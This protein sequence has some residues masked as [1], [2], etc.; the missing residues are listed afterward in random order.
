M[1]LFARKIIATSHRC[2]GHRIRSTRNRW[3]A[4]WHYRDSR[5]RLCVTARKRCNSKATCSRGLQFGLLCQLVA[6]LSRRMSRRSASRAETLSIAA[7]RA[8]PNRIRSSASQAVER[9]WDAQSPHLQAF[10]RAKQCSAITKPAHYDVVA[11]RG[12]VAKVAQL[13][14]EWSQT[15]R[16]SRSLSSRAARTPKPDAQN[17]FAH[18]D[19]PERAI[20][21]VT[22]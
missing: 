17:F 9:R 22:M 4:G 3:V 2:K 1:S 10:W 8:L 7:V 18:A 6:A 15:L 14:A 13:M 19:T 21:A 12:K 5:R 20:R 11:R 16:I